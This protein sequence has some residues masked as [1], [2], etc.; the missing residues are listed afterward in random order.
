MDD[1]EK[2]AYLDQ[3]K[4]EKEK[5]VPFFPD[6]ILKDAI[7]S[8]L[9]FIILASLA[10]FIGVPMEARANPADV[11][12]T[13]RPEWYFLFLF[14]L[15]K[16]FPGKLE[17][18]G[19]IIIPSLVILLM[20][21]LPF[22]DKSPKRFFLNRPLASIIGLFAVVGVVSLTILAVKES[23]PPQT[24]TVVD[25]AADLYAKNCSN[26]HGQSIT[27]PPGTDLHNLIASGGHSGMPAWGADL[28]TYEID[29]LAGFILSPKGSA[30]YTTEC[31][32]CHKQMVL[33]AGD[34]IELQKVLNEGT[35]YP[36][37]NGL[38]VPVWKDKLSD[39]AMNALQ[40]FL[41][42]PDGE[43]L[44]AE[45]CSGCHGQGISFTGTESQLR[46]II[47]KGGQHISMPAWGQTLSQNDLDILASYVVDPASNFSGK[48]LFD[49]HCTACHGNKVPKVPDIATAEKIIS[50]GGPHVSM[51]VWGN[52]LTKE[53]LDAL[54]QYAM[55]SSK[56]LTPEIGAKLF[57]DNCAA[58][59]GKYGQGGPNP[60]NP[61]DSIISISSNDFLS[62][63]DDITIR[64]IIEKGQPDF[65]MPSFGSNFGGSLN[66]DQLD[67]LVAYI[68]SWEKNPPPSIPTTT[69]SPTLV[70]PTS[71]PI[72]NGLGTVTPQSN[73]S[74]SNDIFPIFQSNCL[75]CHNQQMSLGGWDSSSY[76]SIMTTGQNGPV[77]IP[78]DAS[79]SLLVKKITGVEA[80]MPPSGKMQDSLIQLI[81]DW[82]NAG[83][84][85]N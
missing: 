73:P 81:I 21:L 10:Y 22:I 67:A 18:I 28:S 47:L 16:Y 59:H 24:A 75:A 34:P 8:I 2:K 29:Q 74:F 7:V 84:L 43:R 1:K 42:A 46:N 52:V 53:Q 19:V 40:N 6:I 60:L 23:P 37:H 63:R 48:I 4:K 12:Y 62:T 77:I 33:A 56:G 35:T 30:I 39:D 26:C 49:K 78:G 3:Y 61:V 11:T 38:N 85:N 82:I 70:P 50:T 79:S 72:G 76:D 51:P 13:P 83:A 44:F 5:G 32:T 55:S 54:V 68:R 80:L 71:T 31:G 69:P 64:N 20:F 41:A 27:V 58:C 45:N 14:Q 25:Q 57:S 17:V 66:D 15:L 9:V 36:P 65:G